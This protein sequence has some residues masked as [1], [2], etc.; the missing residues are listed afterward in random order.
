MSG[1]TDK[2][3]LLISVVVPVYFGEPFLEE[4]ANRVSQALGDYKYE[5]IFVDDH[6]PDRSWSLIEDMCCSNSKLTGIKL[7]RNFG[8]HN[9][10]TAGLSSCKG[11]WIVIMDCDLQD[12]PEEIPN[13]LNKAKSGFKIVQARRTNRNDSL[14]KKLT[15][16]LFYTVFKAITGIGHNH[17]IAN[18]GVYHRTVVSAILSLGDTTRFTPSLIS[19][20]GFAKSS[21]EVKHGRRTSGQSSYTIRSL[22][23]LA[24]KSIISFSNRPLKLMINLGLALTVIS[25]GMSIYN[26]YLFWCG[27]ISV[28]GYASLIISIWFLSGVILASMGVLGLYVGETFNN[29]KHRPLFIVEKTTN[30]SFQ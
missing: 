3:A 18:F 13:L 17:E 4:L 25:F 27:G 28:P 1:S 11:D 9:A 16:Y 19:W 14:I 22:I 26:L 10:I 21:I 30:D 15:S 24:G 23:A 5:I 20:V 7:S 12:L 6:S 2:N 29:T 8:Q